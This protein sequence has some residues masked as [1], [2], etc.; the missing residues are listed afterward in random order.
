MKFLRT[1]N[2]SN[3]FIKANN[4]L[5]KI[6]STSGIVAEFAGTQQPRWARYT[7]SPTCFMYTLLPLEFGPDNRWTLPP[8]SPIHVLFGMNGMTV[9]SCNGCRPFTISN[10]NNLIYYM[11]LNFLSQISIKW[12]KTIPKWNSIKPS[13]DICQSK[14]SLK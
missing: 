3:Y 5:V 11:F 13:C 7:M 9:F 1:S 10:K 12:P 4:F 8:F 14:A 6:L 2:S